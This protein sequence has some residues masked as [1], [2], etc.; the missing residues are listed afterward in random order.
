LVAASAAQLV[1]TANAAATLHTMVYLSC[2]MVPI[3]RGAW[4]WPR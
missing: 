1:P 2:F 3:L 4:L